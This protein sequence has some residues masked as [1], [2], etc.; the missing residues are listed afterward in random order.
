MSLGVGLYEVRAGPG[1]ET[2]QGDHTWIKQVEKF[3]Q[4]LNPTAVPSHVTFIKQVA[5]LAHPQITHL[6]IVALQNP[7]L[8]AQRQGHPR[9][10]SFDPERA[11]YLQLAG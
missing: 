5:A 11:G 7:K 10:L 1:I 9:T 6:L 4:T 8:R 3:S 2:A